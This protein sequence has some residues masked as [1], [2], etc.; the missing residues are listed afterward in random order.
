MVSQSLLIIPVAGTIE[1]KLDR[2]SWRHGHASPLPTSPLRGKV[3]MESPGFLFL[4]QQVVNPGADDQAMQDP[5]GFKW[6]PQSAEFW[7][8]AGSDLK[9]EYVSHVIINS[10]TA[11]EIT[12]FRPL[13]EKQGV[14]LSIKNK[15]LGLIREGPMRPSNRSLTALLFTEPDEAVYLLVSVKPT[16]FVKEQPSPERAQISFLVTDKIQSV[17]E[18]YEELKTPCSRSFISSE[19]QS[20]WYQGRPIPPTSSSSLLPS[21]QL[22]SSHNPPPVSCQMPLL[23]SN[24]SHQIMDTNP[25]EE[26]SP[27][28]YLLRACSGPQQ[29]SSSGHSLVDGPKSLAPVQPNCSN[30]Q[31]VPIVPV[32]RMEV[33]HRNGHAYCI[34][35]SEV[36]NPTVINRFQSSTYSVF[37]IETA[38]QNIGTAV[39]MVGG[40]GRKQHVPIFRYPSCQLGIKTNFKI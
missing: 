14:T 36:R 24:T 29:A 27:N 18:S 35:G 6:V 13:S 3:V 9:V 11:F 22:P 7:L 5:L 10:P 16:G 23:D 1:R 4:I 37:G 34:V 25:D 20:E 40:G 21:A 38:A 32:P 15:Y 8:S 26:F 2:L 17:G 33:L 39:E 28:S 30:L 12:G 31:S 19:K